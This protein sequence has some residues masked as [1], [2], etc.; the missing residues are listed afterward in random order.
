MATPQSVLTELRTVVET[1]LSVTQYVRP[2][3]RNAKKLISDEYQI[4]PNIAGYMGDSNVRYVVCQYQI[5]LY[6]LAAEL[7]PMTYIETIMLTQQTQLMDPE[8]Y[9]PIPG[10]YQVVGTPE[11]TPNDRPVPGDIML[12]AVDVQLAIEPE[13]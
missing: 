4:L 6:H 11:L 1:R 2:F 10:V 12:W 8:T 3:L 5:W 7:F 13:P 9:R